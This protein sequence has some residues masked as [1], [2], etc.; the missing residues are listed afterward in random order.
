VLGKRC[1]S[2]EPTYW[3]SKPDAQAGT[4]AHRLRFLR[5]SGAE[6]APLKESPVYSVKYSFYVNIRLNSTTSVK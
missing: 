3:R 5:G 6:A 4:L 2:A 1:I